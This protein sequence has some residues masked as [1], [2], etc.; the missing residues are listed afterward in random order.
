MFD[1]VHIDDELATRH[2]YMFGEIYVFPHSFEQPHSRVSFVREKL[3]QFIRK[4]VT[5][6][7]LEKEAVAQTELLVNFRD[8]TS[9]TLIFFSYQVESEAKASSR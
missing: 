2:D 4:D 6:A 8:P 1:S 5:C 7:I 9:S 3:H